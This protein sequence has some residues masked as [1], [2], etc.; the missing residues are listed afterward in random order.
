MHAKCGWS[1]RDVMIADCAY[2][3]LTDY[4]NQSVNNGGACAFCALWALRTSSSR[5]TNSVRFESDRIGARER[6]KKKKKQENLK[7]RTSVHLSAES[8]VC[9]LT[10]ST[11]FLWIC[12]VRHW[13]TFNNMKYR[14]APACRRKVA[15]DLFRPR[16][17]GVRP[18]D[19]L[20]ED[21]KKKDRGETVANGRHGQR[22]RKSHTASHTHRLVRRT[23]TSGS[24]GSSRTHTHLV[25]QYIPEVEHSGHGSVIPLVAHNSN[26]NAC[27]RDANVIFRS[28]G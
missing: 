1:N 5:N 24:G 18:F 10:R 7:K 2:L 21:N 26:E 22:L 17:C 23:S 12:N 27:G 11:Q 4:A 19:E 3:N 6:A 25:T 15:D 28:N 16:C 20:R 13:N 8:V 9:A 14:P